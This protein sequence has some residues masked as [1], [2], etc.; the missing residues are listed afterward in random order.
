[1]E[2]ALRDELDEKEMKIQSLQ[3]KIDLVKD[4]H[5]SENLLEKESDN[6]L[7]S[8]QLTKYLND[9]RS[10]IEALNIKIHE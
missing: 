8:E 5:A 6:K 9:A 2:S 3:T 1:M 4:K 10:E 7:D